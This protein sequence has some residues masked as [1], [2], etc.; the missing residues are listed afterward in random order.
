[1][2]RDERIIGYY[3]LVDVVVDKML[4]SSTYRYYRSYRDDL[5]GEGTIGLILGVD[6]YD[7]TKGASEVS[8]YSRGIQQSVKNYIYRVLNREENPVD[9][10]K[11]D[12]TILT[13]T[14]DLSEIEEEPLGK[15]AIDRGLLTERERRIYDDV[16]IGGMSMKDLSI[17]LGCNARNLR[18][19]KFKLIKRLKDQYDF[20]TEDLMKTK[21][22]GHWAMIVNPDTKYEDKWKIT[23]HMDKDEYKKLKD[24]GLSPK[25]EVDD[26][27]NITY[28]YSFFRLVNKRGKAKG[29]N[30]RPVLVDAEGKP[31]DCLIGNGSDV[32]VKHKPYQWNN[33]HGKGVGTD[34]QGVQVV[35]L[36][37]Y[38][39]EGGDD[40]V[41]NVDIDPDDS[42]FDVVVKEEKTEEV[43]T[44]KDDAFDF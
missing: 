30:E 21:G 31:M 44:K 42:D 10:T 36:I 16:I 20:S 11:I 1:M 8:F 5:I 19:Q 41:A 27:D 33:E 6:K 18:Q 35:N 14:D 24:L 39:S 22:T 12:Q 38:E 43:A 28:Y 15:W 17:E 2:T 9:I 37:P 3:G 34:L 40:S 7:S 25:L 26:D 23:V 29:Q 32:V 13:A 4:A